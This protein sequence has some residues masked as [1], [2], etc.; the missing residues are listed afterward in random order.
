MTPVQ[1]YT[2]L[3]SGLLKST[4]RGVPSAQLAYEYWQQLLASRQVLDHAAYVAGGF[5]VH[6]A[7]VVGG[8]RVHEAHVAGGFSVHTAVIPAERLDVTANAARTGH[9]Q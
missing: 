6:A 4:Q 5:G 2:T 8:C 3:I 9:K 7:Y 1:V